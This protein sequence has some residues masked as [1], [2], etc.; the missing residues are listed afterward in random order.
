MEAVRLFEEKSVRG[1][2]HS[3]ITDAS[4]YAEELGFHLR[5]EYPEPMCITDDDKEV[6]GNKVKGCIAK[7]H[8]EEAR[9]KVKE[10][11]WQGKM[12]CNRWEDVHLEQRDCFAWL[13]CWKAASTHVVVGIQEHYQQLLPTKVFYHRKV[14]TSGSG[15]ERCRMCGKA[16][17]SAHIS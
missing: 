7:A 8:E 13:S 5:L 9:A 10:E 2:R 17:E 4:R 12:I 16:T 6:N 14:G 3:V 1:G 11:K 15:E